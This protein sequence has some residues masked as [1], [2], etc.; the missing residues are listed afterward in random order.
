MK[1]GF[2]SLDIKVIA[3]ELSQSITSLRVVNI[4]DLSSRIFL[5][6]F[7]KPDHRQQFVV[8]S[9]FRCHL[10]SFARTA[11]AAPTP[12]VARLRKFLKTRRV[13]QVSQVGTDRILEIQFSDG[14][15]RLFF[16]FYARGNI[17]L[18]DKDL[19]IIALFRN[20]HEGLEHERIRMG[21]D[22]NL[23]E[24]Q[25]I[26]GIP[27]LN[28][29][30][31]RAGLERYIQRQ[32]DPQQ[33]QSKK[34]R[35]RSGD[36]LRKALA[37]SINE[38]PPL[39]LEH[40][41]RVSGFDV[42]REPSD[43]L[44]DD[45]LVSDVVNALWE[46]QKIVTDIMTAETIR[47]YIIGKPK[48]SGT[49][50][51]S[52][53]SEQDIMY[54]DFH[55]FKPK[56]FEDDP[57][58]RILQFDGFN[59]AVDE[60]FSSIEGQKLESR[61]T[62]KEETARRKMEHA[63]QDQEKRLG[64]LQEV[65]SLNVQKAQAIEAN[66]ARVGE[67]RAAING[68]IAQGIDWVEI[69]R[70]I[71]LEQRRANPVAMVIKTPLKLQQNTATLL[72][73]GF[74]DNDDND[75]EGDLTES[76]PS[77]SDD[78]S[79]EAAEQRPVK[80]QAARDRKKPL[81]VDID[82]GLSAWSNAREYYDQKKT[83]AAKEEK[84]LLA[85]TKALKSAQG[86]IEADLKRS[87]KQEK[88]TLRPV[89]QPFWFE[90]FVYCISSDGYLIIGGRD[91]QQME[92]LQRRYFKKGDVFVHANLDGAVPFVIKNRSTTD[93]DP[94][95][96]STLSQAGSLS[97]STSVAW[98][99]K[100]VM[101]A[102]WVT[103]DQVSKKGAT[104]EFLPAGRFTIKEPKNFLPPAQLLLGFA[105][106]FQISESSKARHQKHRVQDSQATQTNAGEDSTEERQGLDATSRD[107]ENEAV[108]D[109]QSEDEVEA[110]DIESNHQGS[111][112]EETL[113]SYSNPLQVNGNTESPSSASPAKVRNDLER[114]SDGSSSDQSEDSKNENQEE[115]DN[116]PESTTAN[117]G[118]AGTMSSLPDRTAKE[119]NMQQK[120]GKKGKAKKLAAKYADQ[121]EEDR[122][123]AMAFLGSATGQQRAKEEANAKE[124]RD[125]QAEE[126]KRRRREQH[127]RAQKEGLE[128]E[129]RLA[130]EQ[131]E[132]EEDEQDNA[133]PI[134]LETFV[135][136]PLPGDEILE[137]I[138]ICAPWSALGRYKYR[139]KLQPGSTKKGKAVREILS[140]WA[141]DAAEKRLIDEKSEDTEKIWPR[142]KELIAAWKDAEVFGVIPVGK[143]RVMLPGGN[144]KDGKGQGRGK[145][146]G[147]GGKGSKRK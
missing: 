43:I 70:L 106:V 135:G 82:L 26:S 96:P 88:Q 29:D 122:A 146:G 48:L 71:E 57:A 139:A 105:V 61:L 9:G 13:T 67:A 97:V 35:K 116:P 124:D 4:Y 68:L 45:R 131:D 46:A 53:P 27:P 125:K 58:S 111:D 120:R 37:G 115:V 104:G 101:S 94:I 87:L 114:Q 138:P 17:V 134:D 113:P 128:R 133:R 63:K 39:L 50:D 20:V 108:H 55:P 42:S 81:N 85:S 23:S 21:V 7:A 34:S 75:D 84:T 52:N 69:D 41:L 119:R 142:E 93:D 12:F 60:F 44:K 10:T 59:K 117:T 36:T 90:K 76:E 30:R 110:P 28:A 141:R 54:N 137:A 147:R 118:T 91:A 32:A 51:D 19:K 79:P 140:K 18:T 83:A 95:P 103:R 132:N 107:E 109:T 31:V 78:E 47:G 33:T 127:Q 89:R 126:Q 16:E 100:A 5:F 65:Q 86:K 74:D 129:A 6:K 38:F 92:I 98:D 3:Q 136:T 24:R 11:A 121:D 80:E 1:Q 73:N 22:Y 77:S 130:A 15:Y 49:T 66:L 144:S 56:Q 2:S 112:D 145:P 99:S 62:E 25:N 143:L 64:G 72:L 8:E 102:W 123:A 40:A 14:Q